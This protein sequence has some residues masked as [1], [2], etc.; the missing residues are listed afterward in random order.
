M[1]DDDEEI[2]VLKKTFAVL[3]ASLGLLFP[4]R[5]LCVRVTILCLSV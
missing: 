2:D 1:K 3:P 5:G 4:G